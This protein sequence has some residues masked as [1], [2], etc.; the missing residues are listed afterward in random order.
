MPAPSPAPALSEAEAR[1]LGPSSPRKGVLNHQAYM[2]RLGTVPLAHISA[3]A[4]QS[5][6]VFDRDKLRDLKESIRAKGLLQ[7]IALRQVAI[8]RY[9]IVA[10][11]RRYRVFCD[12]AAEP[13]RE[14]HNPT[15]FEQIPA[16]IQEIKGSDAE[17][18]AY[19]SGLLENLDREDLT[20]SETAAA[21]TQLHDVFG[22]TY[23]MIAQ[24][25][26]RALQ[27]VEEYASLGRVPGVA[28][29][30]G[31]GRQLTLKQG[32][33]LSRAGDPEVA[34][35]LIEVSA[36]R[37]LAETSI[38]ARTARSLPADMPAADKVAEAA[39]AAGVPVVEDLGVSFKRQVPSSG[40]R[41]V[42]IDMV[43]PALTH[44]AP[45]FRRREVSRKEFADAVQADCEE[46]H[47]W[48]KRPAKRRET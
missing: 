6:T 18:D 9:T 30:T 4:K 12:L 5:R 33:A 14:G 47:F 8:E 31:E 22:W 38:M 15:D 23:E 24:K 45:L 37:T 29:A 42:E 39:R 48:P 40:R 35:G 36:G 7:P 41:P 27:R 28:E 44:L 10:G 43:R 21:M 20:S 16:L 26:G 34:E 25:S 2:R 46:L 1:V 11:E 32:V 3:A 17:G 13:A 19:L